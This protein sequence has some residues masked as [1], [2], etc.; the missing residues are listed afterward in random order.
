MDRYIWQDNSLAQ[1]GLRDFLRQSILPLGQAFIFGGMNREIARKGKDNFNSD[2]DVVVDASAAVVFE[3]ASTLSATPNKFGGY[4][5]RHPRWKIDFWALESTWAAK[6]G[7]V[8]LK[9][10]RDLLRCTFFDCDA[11]LYDLQNSKVQALD[12]YLD[13]LRERILD[14]NLRPNPSPKGNLVRAVRRLL[15]WGFQPGP[16]LRQFI[17]EHL[18]QATFLEIIDTERKVYGNSAAELFADAEYLREAL[19][20]RDNA[21]FGTPFAPQILLPNL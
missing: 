13:K 14:I 5:Y 19:F 21:R 17:S 6:T 20:S 16:A 1:V 8:E 18:D 4:G 7:H 11:I 9:S 3:L 10:A 12:G 15:Y 2:V